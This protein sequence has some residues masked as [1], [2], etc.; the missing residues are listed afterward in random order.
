[1]LFIV[2]AVGMAER[3]FVQLDCVSWIAISVFSGVLALHFSPKE[4]GERL[5]LEDVWGLMFSTF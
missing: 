5:H 3:W 2:F 4:K 1:M